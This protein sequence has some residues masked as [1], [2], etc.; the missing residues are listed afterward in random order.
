MGIMP[1]AGHVLLCNRDDLSTH[2]HK[3]RKRLRGFFMSLPGPPSQAGCWQGR[4]MF[5]HETKVWYNKKNKMD[6][7]YNQRVI[8]ANNVFSGFFLDAKMLYLYCFNQLPS[9]NYITGIDSEKAY[10]AFKEKFG[11]RIVRI[12]QY[13]CYKL[14]RKKYQIDLPMTV[15]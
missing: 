2:K 5:I 13:S 8:N 1:I 3:P 9:L 7:L 6:N 4:G 10:N 14:N 11:H 12:H 15:R